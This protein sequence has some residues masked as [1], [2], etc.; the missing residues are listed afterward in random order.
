MRERERAKYSPTFFPAKRTAMKKHHE[1]EKNLIGRNAESSNQSEP[2]KLISAH[3][4]TSLFERVC[5]CVC[6]CMC[7]CACV[8]HKSSLVCVLWYTYF[9]PGVDHLRTKN[10]P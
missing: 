1:T 6:V 3:T 9:G 4:H 5:V 2:F 10:N 7:V 8:Y